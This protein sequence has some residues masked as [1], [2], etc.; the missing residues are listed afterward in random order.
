MNSGRENNDVGVYYYCI[1]SEDCLCA[2]T[3]NNAQHDDHN[4]DYIR[5]TTVATPAL[6]LARSA[7]APQ[8]PQQ[9]Q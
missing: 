4:G 2:L 7:S 3:N 1:R 6:A 9:L 5:T 8:V